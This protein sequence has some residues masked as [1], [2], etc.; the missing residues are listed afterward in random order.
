[1]SNF[2]SFDILGFHS[3]DRDLGLR[4]INGAD[5]L[6]PSDN[7]WDWIG[8]GVYFWEGDPARALE[9]AAHTAAGK[10]KNKK[11]PKNTVRNRLG[12]SAWQLPKSCGGYRAGYTRRGV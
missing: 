11:A 3:C 7:Q 8:P 5:E 12:Y 6:K 1:M 2:Q 9:Y 10:L 4:L